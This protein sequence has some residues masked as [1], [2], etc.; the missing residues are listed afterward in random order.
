MNSTIQTTTGI[1]RGIAFRP[2]DGEAM[3]EVSSCRVEPGR[4]LDLENRKPGK[5]EVTL[6]SAETWLEVCR[7]LGTQL[8]WYTR[9]ANLL[10]EG[11]D[12]PKSVGKTLCIGA[13]RILIHGET[14]PCGLMD[15]QFAGLRETLKPN[16]RGGVH[17]EVITGGELHVSDKV[18]IVEASSSDR[19]ESRSHSA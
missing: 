3:R 15:Q 5:R 17:G 13:V 1:L 18:L 8:P 4:G 7:E 12:L 19:L 6:L 2:A 11:I 10:I 14:R 9:R 16:M